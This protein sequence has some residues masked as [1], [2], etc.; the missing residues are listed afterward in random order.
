MD[1]ANLVEVWGGVECTVNRVQDVY[2]DQARLS[3]HLD[4]VT[5]DLERFA[6]LGVNTLRTAVLWERHAGGNAWAS[7]DFMLAEMDRLSLR[8]IVGLLHHGSGPDHT[9]LL[10]P[11]FPE[12][13]AA[14]ALQVATR[15]PY[16]VDYT[17]VNE[18]QTTGR[19]SCLYGHWYPHA[20]GM[21]HYVRALYHQIKGIVL[22][23]QAIRS[24]QPD[25]RLIHTEDG[26]AI[27]STPRLEDFR[28]AREHRRWL[29]VDLLCGCV[30]RDHALFGFLLENGLS[31]QEIFWFAENPCP[32]AI[33]GL[34]YYATSDRFLDHRLELYPDRAGGDSGQEPLVDIEA[35]RVRA[36]GISGVGA[37]LREAWSRYGIP[38]AVTEAHLGCDSLEQTRWL[39]EIWKEAKEARLHGVDVRAVTVWALLGSFNWCHLCTQDTGSYEP[40]VFDLSTGEP[41]PTLLTDLVFKMAHGLR[42]PRSASEPGWWRREDRL[43]IPPWT[44]ESTA[45]ARSEEQRPRPV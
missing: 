42:T 12:K 45:G 13:L 5:A 32:P 27:F 6:D 7:T 33:L 34:N 25:A 38:V 28:E 26:G 19:F 8:P 4:R 3:G 43:T 18:P 22:A 15:Y 35:V 17:P 39:A 21:Q 20:R 14:Y 11:E 41:R 9:S 2:F 29:G 37:I 24:V 10:D 40:G 36:E 16:V 31:E 44:D 1:D 23:M 30:T